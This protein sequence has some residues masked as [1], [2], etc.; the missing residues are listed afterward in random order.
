MS[1]VA[2]DD[3]LIVLLP[4]GAGQPVMNAEE[5]AYLTER[6]R[7]YQEDNALA[8]MADQQEL[9]RVLVNE[10]LC[11]R[12]SVWLGQGHDYA[13]G[14]IDEAVLTRDLGNYSVETRQLKKGLGMDK[15]ARD[16]QKGEGSLPDYMQ[17]LLIRAKAFGIMRNEQSARATEL[18]MEL[19]GI[20][21]VY[22]NCGD[23]EERKEMRVLPEDIIQ[24]IWEI[25]RPEIEEIDRSFRQDGPNAQ[26][27]YIRSM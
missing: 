26:R 10:L 6:V 13:Q 15:P 23:D 14:D 1:D 27:M 12:W 25:A 5:V 24:W 18:L 19:I 7:R 3:T 9:D 22:R 2:S 8:N 16:R 20:V 17:K 4:S 11:H 21:T